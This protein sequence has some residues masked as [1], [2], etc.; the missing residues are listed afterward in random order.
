MLLDYDIIFYA[1]TQLTI[2]VIGMKLCLKSL[3]DWKLTFRCQKN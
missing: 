2:S 1:K 3:H